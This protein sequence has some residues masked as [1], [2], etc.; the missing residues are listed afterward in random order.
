MWDGFLGD[1]IL[2]CVCV[3]RYDAIVWGLRFVCLVQFKSGIT[4]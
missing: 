1:W 3:G 2:G 4:R